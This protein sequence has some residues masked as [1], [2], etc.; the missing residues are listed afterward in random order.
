MLEFEE[1]KQQIIKT[2]LCLPKM[3]RFCQK[4]IQNDILKLSR[5]LNLFTSKRKGF[6]YARLE[7]EILNCKSVAELKRKI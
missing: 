3:V 4:K 7:G 6:I 5:I 1:K 2:T